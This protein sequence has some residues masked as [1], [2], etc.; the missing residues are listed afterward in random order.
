LRRFGW[1]RRPATHALARNDRRN[2]L[3][4]LFFPVLQKI[5]GNPEHNQVKLGLSRHKKSSISAGLG[6]QLEQL[7]LEFQ[8]GKLP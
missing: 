2:S 3:Q 5:S 8:Q 7:M 6:F 1:G 4:S